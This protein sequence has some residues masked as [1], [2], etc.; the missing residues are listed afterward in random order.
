MTEEIN[1][2]KVNDQGNYNNYNNNYGSRSDYRVGNRY[3]GGNQ[4]NNRGGGS[5]WGNQKQININNR[6]VQ[7]V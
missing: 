6:N 7:N 4:I 3:R 1:K 5:Y 2:T